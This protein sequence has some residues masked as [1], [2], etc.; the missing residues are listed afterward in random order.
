MTLD[1][2]S[3]K[4]DLEPEH[5]DY[6][7]AHDAQED[8]ARVELWVILAIVVVVLG[9]AFLWRAVTGTKPGPQAGWNRTDPSAAPPSTA[10]AG[11]A[12]PAHSAAPPAPRSAAP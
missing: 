4:P 3:R 8:R 6:A 11:V 7:H 5:P 1:P 10:A 9:G 2:S 12:V